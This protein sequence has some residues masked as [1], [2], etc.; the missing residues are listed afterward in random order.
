MAHQ[1]SVFLENK[2]GHLNRVTNVLKN[3]GINIR[4]MNLIHT[5]NGWGILNLLVSD[6]VQ[7]CEK[8]DEAGMSASLRR[9]VAFEMTDLPGGLDDLLQKVA[10]AGVNFTNAYGRVVESGKKALFFIDVDDMDDV[11]EKLELAGLSPLSDELVY[12]T[13]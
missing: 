12:G 1:V 7:A 6:P 10:Q 3:N 13:K 4:N 8:L 9:I 2:V 11:S 5:A